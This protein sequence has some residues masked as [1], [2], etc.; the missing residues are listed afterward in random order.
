MDQSAMAPSDLHAT[1][2]EGMDHGTHGSRRDAAE[3]LRSGAPGSI[4]TRPAS[5]APFRVVRVFRGQAVRGISPRLRL[6]R[7]MHMMIQMMVL[8]LIAIPPGLPR[9]GARPDDPV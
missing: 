6:R 2:W 4:P 1:S 8:S 7:V 5:P 9:E 3:R